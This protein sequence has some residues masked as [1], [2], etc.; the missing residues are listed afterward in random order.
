MNYNFEEVLNNLEKKIRN[1]EV[2]FDSFKNAVNDYKVLGLELEKMLEY[3]S[4]NAKKENKER[5][6]KLY[7][8]F[9]LNNASEMMEKLRSL[10]YALKQNSE[11]KNLID[12][13]SSQAFRI[14]EKTRHSQRDEVMY[15]I[16]RIF[17]VNKK[18]IPSLLSKAFNLNYPNEIFKVLIYSFL[19]GILGG[20]E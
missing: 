4:K 5:I 20:E 11:Y 9:S 19:N 15:M 13:F 14:L 10:G 3:A 17:I 18:E 6:W 12:A 7:K 16:S 1:D 2:D 8:D